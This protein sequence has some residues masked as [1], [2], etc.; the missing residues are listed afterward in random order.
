MGNEDIRFIV[1]SAALLF[2]VVAGFIIY[3]VVLYRNRQLKNKKEQDKR[4][5]AFKQ[6]LLKTQIEIQGTNPRKY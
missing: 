2:A 3:F 1:L 6:E 5:A 4:E